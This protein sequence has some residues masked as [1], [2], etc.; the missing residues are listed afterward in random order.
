VAV[1]GFTPN[2]NL[3][4]LDNEGAI[5]KH[6]GWPTILQR[7]DGPQVYVML[8]H[9]AALKRCSQRLRAE[10]SD[11]HE[12]IRDGMSQVGKLPFSVSMA[13]ARPLRTDR[14]EAGDDWDAVLRSSAA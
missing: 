10:L 8:P 9:F 5:R 6:S 7:E 2:T 4:P 1:Y 13:S 11:L 3:L 12:L 14:A